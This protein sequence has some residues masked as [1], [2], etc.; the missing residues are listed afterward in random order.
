[1]DP[2]G[3][4]GGM[5]FYAYVGNSPLNATDP[6][7]LFPAPYEIADWLD[8]LIN[9]L[10]SGLNGLP[11]MRVYNNITNWWNS[12]F[13]ELRVG[14][15]RELANL[16]RGLTDLLRLGTTFSEVSRNGEGIEGWLYATAVEMK[17]AAELFVLLGS[18]GSALEARLAAAP[19]EAPLASVL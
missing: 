6:S 4:A 17:R 13:P 2:I 19:V 12:H 9:C 16:L 15:P 14:N 11:G 3:L 7:G 5:N 8:K 18:F 1:Q 10:E